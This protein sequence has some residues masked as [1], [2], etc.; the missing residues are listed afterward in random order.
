MMPEQ[1]SEDRYIYVTPK[2][3]RAREEEYLSSLISSRFNTKSYFNHSS[4]VKELKSMQA[5][6]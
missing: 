1:D 5:A 6:N 3:S 4:K 2:K